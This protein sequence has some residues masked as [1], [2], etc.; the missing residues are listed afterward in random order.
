MSKDRTER[1]ISDWKELRKVKSWLKFTRYSIQTR[2]I[3]NQVIQHKC[4]I[5]FRDHIPDY[6]KQ[7]ETMDKAVGW[8]MKYI[9]NIPISLTK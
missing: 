5:I 2:M 1:G 4:H 9:L 8:E 6:S 7:P 3:K